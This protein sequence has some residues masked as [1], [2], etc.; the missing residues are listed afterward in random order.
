[1]TDK[2]IIK[3]D[4]IT[5]IDRS[6]DRFN[7]IDQGD[8]VLAAVSGGPDS[9][10][11]VLSLL[12]LKKKYA[13]KI[14][15]AHLNHGLR[16]EESLRDENFTRMLAQNLE[17]PFYREQID[18]GAHAKTHGLSFEEA[19]RDIR[20][21]FFDQIAQ[22]HG[23]T[24]IATGHNKDD[25]AELVLMNLL[26]GAGTR[27]LSGIPPM[28]EGRY[29]R[30]LIQVSK[31]LILDFL[32]S[33]NQAYVF[34]SSNKDMRYLRNKIRYQLIPQLQSEYNP[35]IID[36]LDRLSN[37]LKQEETFW[38]IQTKKAFQDCLIKSENACLVFAKSRMSNLHPALLNRVFRKAILKIKKDL[39]RISL[40]HISDIIEFCFNTASGIS[41]DLPG[42]IRIYKNKTDIMIK[43]EGA[44]LREIGK[45]QKQLRQMAQEKQD[46]KS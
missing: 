6:I 4:F 25:N 29:I 31:N 8:R 41:L 16:G 32:N 19:G 22:T 27:G 34:D 26:R 10:T 42:Q 5:T 33:E 43:K 13:I 11:L 15:I 39:K 23:Y 21:R 30:P 24:K 46:K 3:K 20:Y 1:M 40:A 37:I 14:G 7:M 2:T 9:V 38:D 35:E 17:L 12:A 18:V 28:R 45:K 44:P 36:A